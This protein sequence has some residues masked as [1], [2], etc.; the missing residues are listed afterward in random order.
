MKTQTTNAIA[1]CCNLLSFVFQNPEAG[2]KIKAIYL[3]GSAVRGQ[4]HAKSDIDLFVEAAKA[5]EARVQQLVNSGIAKFT[6]SSDY[7]KWKLL[8]FA[9]H[10]SIQVVQ[11]QEWDLQL[12]IESEG[13]MLYGKGTTTSNEH[14]VLFSIVLPKKKNEYIK[15]R[16]LLFGRDEDF[17][18]GTGLLQ[19]MR[20]QKLSST[21]FIVPKEEQT[22]M[23]E[24]LS[25]NKIDFSMKEVILLEE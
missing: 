3:F 16:R 8:R 6:V 23:M 18:Q 19:D 15:V 2:K 9:H 24:V 20:G 7:R 22:K 13:I 17:Y 4:L 11:L 14:R 12:S 21:V 10:F 5:D 25:K 1:Y